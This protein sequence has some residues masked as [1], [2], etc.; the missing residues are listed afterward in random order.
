M[1]WNDNNN[2]NPWGNNG[3]TPPELDQ[4]IIDFKKKFSGVFGGKP[5]SNSDT[6]RLP[7]VGGLKYIFILALLV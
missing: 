4:V 3:Q 2:Q 1:A 6:P 5:P 7:S